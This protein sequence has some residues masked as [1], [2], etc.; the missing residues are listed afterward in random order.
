[1]PNAPLPVDLE[2]EKS[3]PEPVA[4]VPVV[5]K[6]GAMPVA[7][8]VVVNEPKDMTTNWEDRYG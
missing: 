6:M 8:M 2:P 4:T 5:S 3:A 7:G 1:V